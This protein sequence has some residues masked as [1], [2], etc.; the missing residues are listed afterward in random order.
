[1]AANLMNQVIKCN[2]REGTNLQRNVS[3]WSRYPP[4]TVYP[5]FMFKERHQ[6]ELEQL[7]RQELQRQIAEQVSPLLLNTI[8]IIVSIRRPAKQRPKQLTNKDWTP[9][10]WKQ[11]LCKIHLQHSFYIPSLRYHEDN[12]EVAETV[13]LTDYYED[14]EEWTTA[15]PQVSNSQRKA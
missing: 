12:G 15:I 3:D 9:A 6:Q 8:F 2:K 10:N 11:L 14:V 7:Q 13:D 1:M 4:P 5:L